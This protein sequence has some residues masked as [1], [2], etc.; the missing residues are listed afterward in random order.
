MRENERAIVV[1][2]AVYRKCGV[3]VRAVHAPIGLKKFDAD[4]ADPHCG[5]HTVIISEKREI[6]LFGFGKQFQFSSA[7]TS[8]PFR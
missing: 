7:R 8:P 1:K 2:H 3:T 5:T 4:C 6:C